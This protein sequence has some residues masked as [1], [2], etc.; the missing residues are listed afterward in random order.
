MTNNTITALLKDL[1]KY[2]T[3]VL[4]AVET[5]DIENFLKDHEEHIVSF[6]EHLGIL[7]NNFA[8]ANNETGFEGRP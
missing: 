3:L 6:I 5:G 4:K 1:K 2:N 7:A 8:E